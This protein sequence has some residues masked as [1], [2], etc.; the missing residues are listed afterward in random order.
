MR[1]RVS[2]GTVSRTYG[3]NINV[4]APTLVLSDPYRGT[5]WRIGRIGEFD[6]DSNLP[7][8]ERVMLEISRDGGVTW[9]LIV[10]SVPVGKGG[11]EYEWRVTGPATT[12]LRGRI[13]WLRGPAVSHTTTENGKI[14]AATTGKENK[15][16]PK[17]PKE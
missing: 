7:A 8:S 17:K 12:Q 9:E 16:K 15:K 2:A 1:F 4:I 6:W 13:T 11:D 14:T 3:S 10:A 5:N